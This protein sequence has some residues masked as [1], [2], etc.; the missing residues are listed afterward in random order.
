MNRNMLRLLVMLALVFAAANG[1]AQDQP[2]PDPDI[3]LGDEDI[4][5]ASLKALTILLVLSVLIENAL[6]VIFNWR[7]FRTYFSVRGV[8]TIISFVVSFLIVRSFE[9][10]VVSSLLDA[11]SPEQGHNSNVATEILTALIIAGGSSGIH[12]IMYSMGYRSARSD[13]EDSRPPKNKAWIAVLV[14]QKESV[15]PVHVNL[16]EDATAPV[17]L[18]AIAG[19]CMTERPGLLSLLMRNNNRFP[20]NGGHEVTPGQAYRISVSGKNREGETV[21]KDVSEE[22][23]QL[24]PGA[25]V[26]FKVVL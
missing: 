6:A 1:F 22:A 3:P 24:A 21:S 10:D 4:Y 16:T 9:V 7:V 18:P 20:A 25:I 12:N 17:D 2:D 26:D 15:G 5:Q 8:K 14:D 23:V 11:Y 19:T 13:D